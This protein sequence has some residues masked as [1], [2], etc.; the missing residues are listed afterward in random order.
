MQPPLSP[1]AAACC[2][3]RIQQPAA[4]GT[5]AANVLH[6][7]VPRA[8]SFLC[9][10]SW[11]LRPECFHLYTTSPPAD[12]ADT[13]P[14]P[15]S[16]GQQVRLLRRRGHSGGAPQQ[17]RQPGCGRAL[18][19]PQLLHGGRQQA[20]GD[21]QGV[22]GGPHA[23]RWGARWLA[24]CM[25]DGCVASAAACTAVLCMCCGTQPG[26]H[27]GAIGDVAVV[28]QCARRGVLHQGCTYR[29]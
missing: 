4:A 1:P 7:C 11:L 17:G 24:S 16:P 21:R 15:H 6:V 10:S 12:P 20:G 28:G 25:L 13:P 3:A 14:P 9:R 26:N 8:H 27:G 19:V 29:P 23:H 5:A 2:V 22:Q 18:E